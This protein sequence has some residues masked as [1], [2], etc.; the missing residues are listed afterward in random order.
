MKASALNEET[1]ERFGKHIINRVSDFVHELK[2]Y[3]EKAY[4]K[5]LMWASGNTVLGVAMLL[6]RHGFTD[7]EWSDICATSWRKAK[8]EM[9]ND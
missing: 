8:E 4:A 3:E 5:R 7:E 6:M 9:E 1:R 2:P